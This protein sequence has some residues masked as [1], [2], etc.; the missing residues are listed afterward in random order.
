MYLCIEA[1]MY[2][3]SYPSTQG[4]PAMDAG[5][6]SEQFQLSLKP[7]MV[8]SQKSTLGPRSIDFEDEL[9]FP[10]RTIIVAVIEL[11][12]RRTWEVIIV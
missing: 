5:G 6:I 9:R 7:T 3:Y 8:S 1:S 2:Q 12:W 11:D 4:I 10:N